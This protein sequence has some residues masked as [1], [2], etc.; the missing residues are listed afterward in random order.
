MWSRGMLFTGLAL[1]GAACNFGAEES[2]TTEALAPVTTTTTPVTTTAT[3][4]TTLA[5][6]AGPAFPDYTIARRIEATD[7]RDTVVVL[8]DTSSYQ[9]LTAE[10][11]LE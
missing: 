8:L 10:L 5:A 3:T 11:R 9:I 6:L 2:T 4:T 1:L 7:G